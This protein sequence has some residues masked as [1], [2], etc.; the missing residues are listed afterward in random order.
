M[1]RLLCIFFLALIPMLAL[2]DVAEEELMERNG[3]M[4]HINSDPP[5][6]LFDGSAFDYHENGE[7]HSAIIYSKGKRNG[8]ST[9][10]YENGKVKSKS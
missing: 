10:Y 2:G 9:V 5:Y 4:Y 3:V 6:A 7:L 8:L 1:E